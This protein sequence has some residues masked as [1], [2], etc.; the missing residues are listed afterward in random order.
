M[1]QLAL[2]YITMNA[3]DG[4]PGSILKHCLTTLHNKV[5]YCVVVDGQLTPQ[6]MDF[7]KTIP[8]LTVINSPWTGRHVEQYHVRNE[9]IP[10]G[11]WVLCMDCDELPSDQLI[12]VARQ[13]VQNHQLPYNICYSPSITYLAIDG[14]NNF[15]RIQEP[16]TVEDFPRRSKRLLYKRQENNYFI[17]SPCGKHVTPTHIKGNS[18]DEVPIGSKDYIHY[19]FKTIESFILN[20]CIYVVSNPRHESGPGARQ[21]TQ[22]QENTLVDLVT[23]YDY[24]NTS[25][26]I[27]DTKKGQ[28]PSDFRDFVYQF[29]GHLGQSMSKFYY[30]YEFL[31]KKDFTNIKEL[32]SCI[33]LGFIPVYDSVINKEPPLVIPRTPSIWQ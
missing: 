20:E 18:L 5:D 15:I 11:D 31:R 27:E 32:I 17:S 8:N 3:G 9:A 14:T 23:K 4:I 2:T 16:P 13:L 25:K 7:Y 22:E 1:S 10:I 21:L 12:H 26:F 19:H 6:A 33:S 24:K 29:K 28:W 30:L